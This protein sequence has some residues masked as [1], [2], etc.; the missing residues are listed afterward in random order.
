M[1]DRNLEF[2]AELMEMGIMFAADPS[3]VER[4]FA[5]LRPNAHS[6]PS[7]N[8]AAANHDREARTSAN[9]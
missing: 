4:M 5:T 9:E 1:F 7:P 3:L 2:G 6:M 8:V